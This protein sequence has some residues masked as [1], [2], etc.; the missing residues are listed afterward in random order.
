M[1]PLPEWIDPAAWSGYEEMRRAMKR[2][3]TDRA[4]KMVLAE[5]YR[6][7]EAGHCPNGALDQSTMRG[8]IDVYPAKAKEIE[9]RMPDTSDGRIAAEKAAAAADK[10][11]VD[12]YI[13]RTV[14]T[15]RRVV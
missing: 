6:I 8:W 7:K 5:L 10:A 3:F 13:A 12:A 15:I 11:R 4:A 14:G 9:R 2:P 1:I